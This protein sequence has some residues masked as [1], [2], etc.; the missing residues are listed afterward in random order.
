[1]ATNGTTGMLRDGGAAAP[2]APNTNGGAAPSMNAAEGF[3]PKAN[4]IVTIG[5]SPSAGSREGRGSPAGG[6]TSPPARPRCNG[7]LGLSGDVSSC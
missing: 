6:G 7:R 4:K 3:D 5:E 1:M 2:M